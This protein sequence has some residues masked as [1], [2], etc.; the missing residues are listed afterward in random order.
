MPQGA[1]SWHRSLS[2]TVRNLSLSGVAL[3]QAWIVPGDIRATISNIADNPRVS[4]GIEN[5]E[6]DID[7]LLHVLGRIARQPPARADNPFA[8]TQTDVQRPMDEFAQA[9][10][11]R[12]YTQIS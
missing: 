6:E 4:L 2:V 12:V 5:S 10:A 7:T 8:P 1:N 3:S 11:R 9:A